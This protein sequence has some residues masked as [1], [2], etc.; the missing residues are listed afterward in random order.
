MGNDI[1]RVPT[2]EPAT[3]HRRP[4]RPAFSGPSGHRC[5]GHLCHEPQQTNIP[6]FENP[7][8]EAHHSKRTDQLY[9]DKD[10]LTK[11]QSR[12][13]KQAVEVAARN[14]KD[15]AETYV[16]D[17]T[18]GWARLVRTAKRAKMTPLEYSRKK[19]I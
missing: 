3:D 1:A 8:Q 2:D 18:R 14:F 4:R 9:L 13:L 12:D 15:Q 6:L 17:G 7:Q 16:F 11:G 19:L 5:R 10:E